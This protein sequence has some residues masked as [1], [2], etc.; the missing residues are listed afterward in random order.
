MLKKTKAAL[1][2]RQCRNAYQM[3]SQ[4]IT[5]IDQVNSLLAGGAKS[6]APLPQ[7]AAVTLCD[8]RCNL[9]ERGGS[10]HFLSLCFRP[11]RWF[12]SRS[13]SEGIKS[14]D[15]PAGTTSFISCSG[16]SSGCFGF[17]VMANHSSFVL[18]LRWRRLISPFTALTINCAFVSPSSRLFSSSATTS[19]GKRAFNCC[20]LLL[21]E[22]VAITE[23]PCVKCDSV[24]AKKMI[25]K[26]L[27]CD[28][29]ESSFKSVGAIHL[30][31]AK[32]RSAST[33]TGFLTPN[34]TLTSEAAMNNHTIPLSG[35]DSLTLNKFTWR[36][37]ALNRHDKKA[38]PCRLSVEATTE[39]EARRILAPHFILSFAARLP[40]TIEK[41]ST[42]QEV[43]HA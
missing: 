32:P 21:V 19:C 14:S 42:V 31:N 12:M 24:Y 39:H 2:G 27:K 26:G 30:V 4:L 11:K 3:P 41:T 37:L 28:S 10:G 22:P 15:L 36:F 40:V 13:K 23:S 20:D 33:L 43:H 34:A 38:K 9:V 25:I 29:L 8:T 35:R 5:L 6:T 17:F 7:V 18:A 16:A 1:Q